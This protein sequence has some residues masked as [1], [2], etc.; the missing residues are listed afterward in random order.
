MADI[1]NSPPKLIVI[2]EVDGDGAFSLKRL[3]PELGT[4]IAKNYRRGAWHDGATFHERNET[5]R[6]GEVSLSR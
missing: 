1:E 2:D 6:D 3:L 5:A 4:L